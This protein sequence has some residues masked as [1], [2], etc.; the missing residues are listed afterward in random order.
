MTFAIHATRVLPCLFFVRFPYTRD[1]DERTEKQFSKRSVM[2]GLRSSAHRLRLLN[3]VVVALL[4]IAT[5][6]ERKPNIIFILADDLGWHDLSNEGSMFYDSPHIDRIAREGMKFTRGYATCQVRSPSLASILT[7]KYSTKHGIA[8][9]IGATS[10]EAWRK[11]HDS[12][13]SPEYERNFRASEIDH[14]PIF[15]PN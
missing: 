12:H 8:T 9:W 1:D 4:A 7:G 6:D 14:L 2:D 15:V 10:G 5:A 11:R 13:L 3:G